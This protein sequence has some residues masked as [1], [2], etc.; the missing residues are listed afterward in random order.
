MRKVICRQLMV[1]VYMV[2]GVIVK[3]KRVMILRSITVGLPRRFSPLIGSGYIFNL[4]I[5]H[6]YSNLPTGNSNS[7]KYHIA[8]F[9]YL[10]SII[11]SIIYIILFLFLKVR[12]RNIGWEVDF[13]L[14]FFWKYDQQLLGRIDM[15]SLP[16]PIKY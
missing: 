11:Y 15:D 9:Y 16:Q 3:K 2:F 14:K 12:R 5:A 4:Y 10:F 13:I 1:S 8:S 6:I 7:Y